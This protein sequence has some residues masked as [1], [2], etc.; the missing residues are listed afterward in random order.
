MQAVDLQ[1]KLL[2][3]D[4]GAVGGRHTAALFCGAPATHS[5]VTPGASGGGVFTGGRL[6]LQRF[7]ACTSV[8]TH[9]HT[10]AHTQMHWHTGGGLP[11]QETPVSTAPP[12][13]PSPCL[14]VGLTA[15]FT[16]EEARLETPVFRWRTATLR[17]LWMPDKPASGGRGAGPG[18]GPSQVRTCDPT[19]KV[20]PGRTHLSWTDGET[21]AQ[22]GQGLVCD[23]QKAGGRA[24][25][26]LTTARRLKISVLQFQGSF[27]TPSTYGPGPL[28]G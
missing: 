1:D 26:F 9:G 14:E 18:L 23:T 27:E 20:G 16:D 17:G 28:C 10:C 3:Q 22:R 24:G 25:S 13:P 7:S 4:L 5:P 6:S 8:Y 11:G 15:L 21:K 2:T 12:L 19:F